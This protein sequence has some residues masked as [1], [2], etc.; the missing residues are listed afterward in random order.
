MHKHRRTKERQ[1]RDSENTDSGRPRARERGQFI[2]H[3]APRSENHPQ[4][5]TAIMVR[6]I[7]E[8][9][10]GSDDRF[11]ALVSGT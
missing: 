3:Q 7:V 8:K 5:R 4:N 1:P 2:A 6:E 11:V 9:S 10:L